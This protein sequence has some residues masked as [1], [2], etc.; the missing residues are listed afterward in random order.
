MPRTRK[1]EPQPRMLDLGEYVL[2]RKKDFYAVLHE[3]GITARLAGLL[4]SVYEQSLAA[5]LLPIMRDGVKQL[6]ATEQ[7]RLRAGGGG[8]PNA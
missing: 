8:T 5:G 7:R 6:I 4:P 1:R 3:I 2:V